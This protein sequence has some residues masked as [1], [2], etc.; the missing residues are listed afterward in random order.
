MGSCTTSGKSPGALSFRVRV[1]A[2]LVLDRRTLLRPYL[3][4]V[5][6]RFASGYSTVSKLRHFSDVLHIAPESGRTPV[7]DGSI[8][9]C[10]FSYIPL[11]S[12]PLDDC[13]ENGSSLQTSA[14][15]AQGRSQGSR[16]S[17]HAV[18]RSR[19]VDHQ[20]PASRIRLR[21]GWI[22]SSLLDPEPMRNLT[23]FAR[24]VRHIL[25]STLRT[26]RYREFSLPLLPSYAPP[27]L[28]LPRVFVRLVI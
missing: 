2:S 10:H 15:N 5:S 18:H 23:R 4:S 17:L 22:V 9:H 26:K 25:P 6:L 7:R 19:R 28:H 13:S 1:P 3:A 21:S 27:R 8:S 12:P 20:G 14:T 11:P 24:L 16:S